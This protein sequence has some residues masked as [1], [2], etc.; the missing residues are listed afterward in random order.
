[1]FHTE[2]KALQM[3]TRVQQKSTWRTQ[4]T[5]TGVDAI[6]FLN[7]SLYNMHSLAFE[8]L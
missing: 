8:L 2:V 5:H 1:M 4:S 6:G 7:L 3:L